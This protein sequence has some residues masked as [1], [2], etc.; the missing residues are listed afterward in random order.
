M[1]NNKM[2]NT[3]SSQYSLHAINS[4]SLVSL[5]PSFVVFVLK[6]T[7]LQSVRCRVKEGRLTSV[8]Y[9]SHTV[10]ISRLSSLEL[11]KISLLC[12]WTSKLEALTFATAVQ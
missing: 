11:T 6:E 2:I 12:Y 1:N 8:S 9:C 4:N 5:S 3:Y 7:E 10:Q